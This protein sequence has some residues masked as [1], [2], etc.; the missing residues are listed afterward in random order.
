MYSDVSIVDVDHPSVFMME[1][2]T[3]DIRVNRV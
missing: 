2:A 3:V 1:G